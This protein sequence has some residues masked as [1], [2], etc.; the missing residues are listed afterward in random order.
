MLD[1]VLQLLEL[2]VGQCMTISCWP[3]CSL[4]IS[5]VFVLPNVDHNLT[6]V[7]SNLDK[8]GHSILV[9]AKMVADLIDFFLIFS[10]ARLLVFALSCLES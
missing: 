7:V 8:L 6:T 5:V 4:T 2:S 1:V 9:L 3:A 10:K